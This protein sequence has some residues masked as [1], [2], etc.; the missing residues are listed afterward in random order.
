VEMPDDGQR[1][2]EAG[3]IHVTSLTFLLSILIS[4]LQIQGGLQATRIRRLRSLSVF[5]AL[6]RGFGA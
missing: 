5:F 4:T 6:S 3:S 2:G 1:C